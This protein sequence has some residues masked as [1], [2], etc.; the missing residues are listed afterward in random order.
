M[1][2]FPFRMDE[3]VRARGR[4]TTLKIFAIHHH[5]L[6][7]YNSALNVLGDMAHFMPN[8]SMPCASGASKVPEPEPQPGIVANASQPRR[9]PSGC[10]SVPSPAG[11]ATHG[12]SLTC[13]LE[14]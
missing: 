11:I 14:A 13:I 5:F 10:H 2:S 1:A 12:R 3:D 7:F 8:T 4:D 9:R 6:F